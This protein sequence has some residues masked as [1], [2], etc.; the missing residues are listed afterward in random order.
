MKMLKIKSY[1]ELKRLKTFKERFNY[2]KLN[3]SVGRETF[4]FNRYMN[5]LVYRDPRW[6]KSRDIV[7]MRD[8]GC[9]L[10][11]KGLEIYDSITVHHM[12]PLTIEDIEE[13]RPEIFD[14]EYLISSSVNTHEAIHYS[15]ES[16][17]TKPL[18]ERQK[19]DTC[20]WKV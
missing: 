3:G 11:V 19:N 4:G 2:L 15:D 1:S 17:L 6:K 18:I 7:I 20:P 9:D 10:G 14:P 13:G 16:I 12:N 8:N 5:Q